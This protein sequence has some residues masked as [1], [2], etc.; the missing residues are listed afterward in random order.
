[1]TGASKSMSARFGHIKRRLIRDEPL[2]GDLLKL[3]LDVVGDG[4]SGDAQIDTI[5]NK[6]M[7]GQKLGTY[8]LHLMVDVF[9]LHARLAS[10]SA[11]ANDQFEPKA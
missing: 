5:A 8:E 1:M 10:A 9:L 7:S 11:L 2:T 6:L 4:D 3:A